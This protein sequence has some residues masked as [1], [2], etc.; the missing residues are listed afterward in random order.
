[1]Y[2]KIQAHLLKMEKTF[3]WLSKETGIP[4]SIFTMMKNRKGNLSSENLVKV[5]KALNIPA[6]AL[7]EGE[8]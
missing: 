1:M 2:E 3:Y 8:G 5:A 4:T 7:I 6:E